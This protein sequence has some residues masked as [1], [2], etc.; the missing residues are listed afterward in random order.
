MG[1]CGV[2]LRLVERVVRV[3]EVAGS[4]PVTPTKEKP[5]GF[6][7]LAFLL[8]DLSDLRLAIPQ[9]LLFCATLK[10]S[11]DVL[12]AQNEVQNPVTPTT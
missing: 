10:R 1:G 7:P 12:S 3:H 9:E 5:K 11:K 4:N 6:T 2:W 8:L